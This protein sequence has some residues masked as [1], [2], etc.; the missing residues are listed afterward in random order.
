MKG[1][2]LMGSVL[3]MV[4]I[5]VYGHDVTKEDSADEAF[6]RKV[7]WKES[8]QKGFCIW[9][10]EFGKCLEVREEIRKNRGL[11]DGQPHM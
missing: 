1:I 5:P 8:G 6:C 3:L 10:H 7:A 2:L 9:M 11:V 4:C